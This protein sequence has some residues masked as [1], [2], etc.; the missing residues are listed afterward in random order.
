[1]LEKCPLCN[2]S[3]KRY[4]RSTEFFQCSACKL[5]FRGNSSDQDVILNIYQKSWLLPEKNTLETG[6]TNPELAR[7]YTNLLLRTLNKS[8]LDGLAILDFGAGRGTFSD[9]MSENGA[10]VF[11]YEPFGYDYLARKGYRVI[12]DFSEIKPDLLFDGIVSVDVLE[13]LEKPWEDLQKLTAH[14]KPN[15]WLFLATVNSS[16]LNSIIRKHNWRELQNPSHL[17]M[18]NHHNLE[19]MFMKINLKRFQRLKW[20]VNYHRFF[21]R[22]WLIY[23]QQMLGLDGELRYF[24]RVE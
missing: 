20:K 24:I 9:S 2:S 10:Q 14:V 1:M 5:I 11:L 7:I 16:S 23:L 17:V 13:H 22:Q 4:F 15:G 18:F 21:I 8:S 6:G 19:S 3:I 12:R